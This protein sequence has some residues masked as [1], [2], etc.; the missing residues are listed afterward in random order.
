MQSWVI[1]GTKKISLHLEDANECNLKENARIKISKVPLCKSDIA[2]YENKYDN[3]PIIPGRSAIGLISEC[4][5]LSF[6]KGQRVYVS[7]YTK[8]NNRIFVNAKD[9]D[10]YLSDYQTAPLSSISIVPESIP[11]DSFCFVEDIALCIK[12][13]KLLEIKTTNYVLLY[14]ATCLNILLAQMCLYHQAIP[15]IIDTDKE[16]LDIDEYHGIYYTINP[17]ID[18]V[19]ERLIEITA[20]AMADKLIVDIDALEDIPSDILKYISQNGKAAFIGFNTTIDKTNIDISSIINKRLTIY[21]INDGIGEIEPA[22]NML[23]T[24]IVKVDNLLDKVYDISQ[25]KDAFL[26][27]SSKKI[28]FKSIV[29]C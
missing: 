9:I 23:A 19:S 14:G 18:N 24:G 15:I 20:G 25:V 29:H 28:R 17:K 16:S 26:D 8:E 7:P 3:L 22:I 11:D 5:D 13:I 4:D 6:R 10:G 27:L 12:T 1:N 21:G 2:C